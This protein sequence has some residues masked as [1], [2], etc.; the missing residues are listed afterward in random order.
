MAIGGTSYSSWGGA[1]KQ[2]AAPDPYAGLGPGWRKTG[3]TPWSGP[4]NPLGP[5]NST[6]GRDTTL[7]RQPGSG[8]SPWLALNKS[9]NALATQTQMDNAAESSRAGLGS[10]WNELA[11]KGGSRGGAAER[12]A[13]DA[14]STLQTNKQL[15]MTEG[16]RADLASSISD[17]QWNRENQRTDVANTIA[18]RTARNTYD[19]NKYG[20]EMQGWA[21]QQMSQAI[22]DSGKK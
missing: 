17:E 1:I 14:D 11:A 12:L 21:A 7:Y 10:A 4:A 3:T 22:K 16:R 2:P 9:Q 19:L 6:L 20:Q 5:Y 15:A 8:D 13:S 18:D